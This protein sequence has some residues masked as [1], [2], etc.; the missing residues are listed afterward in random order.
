MTEK[1]NAL[2]TSK[3]SLKEFFGELMQQID[4]QQSILKATLQPSSENE[5]ANLCQYSMC[6]ESMTGSDDLPC[7]HSLH[8][9]FPK[10]VNKA[11][12][13]A[14]QSG[15]VT[16]VILLVD[17][18]CNNLMSYK[19]PNERVAGIMHKVINI[20]YALLVVP[21]TNADPKVYSILYYALRRIR[22]DAEVVLNNQRK[23]WS[24]P[25]LSPA[26]KSQ[27]PM[28]M[29]LIEE[30]ESAI[31]NG[32]FSWMNNEKD[33][34][35]TSLKSIE[36]TNSIEILNGQIMQM[37]DT[38][39]SKMAAVAEQTK[40]IMNELSGILALGFKSLGIKPELTAF[41]SRVSR[42]ADFKS[43]LDISISFYRIGS[44]DSDSKQY[45]PIYFS[46]KLPGAFGCS[47]LLKTIKNII[48]RSQ[49]LF[50]VKLVILNSRIPLIKLHHIRSSIEVDVCIENQLG[51]QN[52]YL[53]RDLFSFNWKIHELCLIIKNWAEARCCN[54]SNN[55]TIST[56]SWCLL[57]IYYLRCVCM[58]PL[59]PSFQ[60]NEYGT[61]LLSEILQGLDVKSAHCESPIFTI[62]NDTSVGK[63]TKSTGDLLL[64]FFSFYG[65]DSPQSFEFTDEMVDIRSNRRK[66]VKD[67][68]SL[69]SQF[70][71]GPTWRMKIR[72]PFVD[73][74]LGSVVRE[75]RAQHFIVEELRR[76]LSLLLNAQGDLPVLVKP[77][78]ELP[79]GFCI[80]SECSEIGHVRNY[81]PRSKCSRCKLFGHRG[82]VCSAVQ[83]ETCRGYGHQASSCQVGA[84]PAGPARA[85]STKGA[86][87]ASQSGQRVS[88]STNADKVRASTN[89][90]SNGK[91]VKDEGDGR[92]SI[93]ETSQSSVPTNTKPRR[94]RGRRGRGTKTIV[95][96][97]SSEYH[98]NTNVEGPP[99]DT[100]NAGAISSPGNNLGKAASKGE[101]ISQPPSKADSKLNPKNQK[102]NSSNRSTV[103]PPRPREIKVTKNGTG[104]KQPPLPRQDNVARSQPHEINMNEQSQISAGSNDR[105][106]SK[107]RSSLSSAA[108]ASLTNA[109]NNVKSKES[110][111]ITD[112]T[113]N[114]IAPDMTS[115]QSM[116]EPI[117]QSV[118]SD[119][120]HVVPIDPPLEDEMHGERRRNKN[121]KRRLQRQR[122]REK[123]KDTHNTLDATVPLSDAPL[124]AADARQPSRRDH[125]S[126]TK[127]GAGRRNRDSNRHPKV[128]SVVKADAA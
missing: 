98:P 29:N 52:T 40:S 14:Q 45:V 7:C 97:K 11:K 108:A 114:A 68:T 66:N 25:L 23:A 47:S 39:I 48:H 63:S 67:Y 95:N 121:I 92:R 41:G 125:N 117:N 8:M 3:D 64:G 30:S 13:E 15:S 35:Q 31:E 90:Q 38:H 57:V 96:N 37:Y 10:S 54:Q 2:T 26:A 116:K 102:V 85:Q 119:S 118:V 42:L 80:C 73:R 58:P 112:L 46:E 24:D 62:V 93:T 115:A 53:L 111:H 18:V 83:C 19:C 101:N 120:N 12:H 113:K 82:V 89:Q 59:V 79:G 94:S 61:H 20:I 60:L 99:S 128:D 55:G 1:F 106:S 51:V 44:S 22:D 88:T 5:A 34:V 100:L 65:S 28:I 81:C 84:K 103:A 123:I 122:Q 21:L 69:T 4:A 76:G 110:G 6:K 16:D 27:L 32:L 49:L 109:P 36:S 43:D 77:N 104:D 56:F 87:A 71:A 33:L 107:G 126:V 91:N 9:P 74:N 105:V 70:E 127:Q 124:P 78:E 72:D 86:N 75:E 17:R 50:E